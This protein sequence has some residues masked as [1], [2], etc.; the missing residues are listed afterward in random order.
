ML[1]TSTHLLLVDPPEDLLLSS[2]RHSQELLLGGL[3]EKLQWKS[4]ASHS[5]ICVL[6]FCPSGE[7][8]EFTATQS[9]YREG[10]ISFKPSS[11]HGDDPLPTFTPCPP[12]PSP[13]SPPSWWGGITPPLVPRSSRHPAPPGPVVAGA[14]PPPGSR[15]R[16]G[17]GGG[18]SH[19]ERRHSPAGPPP[20]LI[21]LQRLTRAEDAV[22]PPAGPGR[23]L[24]GSELEERRTTDG[25]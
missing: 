23:H 3:M 25:G 7:C 18:R 24:A 12:P 11:Q 1:E 19:A 2:F 17:G 8:P 5:D 21:R 15:R 10:S 22:R 20:R 16:G 9:S 13:P 14:K 6:T 4:W